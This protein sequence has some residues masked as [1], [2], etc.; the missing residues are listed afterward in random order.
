MSSSSIS[1]KLKE[2]YS[3]KNSCKIISSIVV[4]LIMSFI[5]LFHCLKQFYIIKTL[6]LGQCFVQSINLKI[7]K[8]NTYPV[9]FITVT[10]N[11]QTNED[12]MVGS[13]SYLTQYRAWDAAHQYRVRYISRFLKIK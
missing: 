1:P 9:W 12:M 8:D 11:N 10:Y 13:D 3:K 7:E 5:L 6:T 2:Y 4:F